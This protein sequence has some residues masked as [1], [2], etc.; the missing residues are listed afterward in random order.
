MSILTADEQDTV[1]STLK[2][3]SEEQHEEL[4][5]SASSMSNEEVGHSFW[6]H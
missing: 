6:L 5:T 2:P 4:K 1:S 3:L